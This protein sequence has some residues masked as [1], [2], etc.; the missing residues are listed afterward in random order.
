[1]TSSL[2]L[3]CRN[4][5]KF[6]SFYYTNKNSEQS[7]LMQKRRKKG[8]LFGFIIFFLSRNLNTSQSIFM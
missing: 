4:I 6:L 5:E 8:N 7:I 2:L 3:L 1:M